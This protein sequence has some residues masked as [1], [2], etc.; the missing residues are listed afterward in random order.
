MASELTERFGDSILSYLRALRTTE[1]KFSQALHTSNT[2][3]P[4]GG[5][6]GEIAEALSLSRLKEVFFHHLLQIRCNT[7][8]VS[9]LTNSSLPPPMAATEE[10][11]RVVQTSEATLGNVIYPT[12][13]LMNH[14]CYP[15]VLFRYGC[16]ELAQAWGVM[17]ILVCI[18]F[19][20]F[21]AAG[22]MAARW[23]S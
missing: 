10:A 13:S 1:L 18:S 17:V 14:S 11:E 4:S 23:L 16:S 21:G 5:G 7:H 20:W 3:N 2:A 6:G 19:N 8:I 12:A 9:T 22:L 15:N